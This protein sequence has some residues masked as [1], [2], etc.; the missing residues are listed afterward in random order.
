MGK[1]KGTVMDANGA[2]VVTPRPSIIFKGKNGVR[3]VVATDSGDYEIALPAGVYEVTTETPGF[4]PFRRAKFH[5]LPDSSVV[6]N[7]VLTPRYIIRGTTVS[8]TESTDTLAPSPQYNQ[9]VVPGRQIRL[10]IQFQTKRRPNG[11]I[12]YSGAILTYDALTIYTDKLSLNKIQLRLK[13]SGKQ[14]VVEDGKQ[15][16]QVKQAAVTFK[17]GE[18]ILDL[19][20]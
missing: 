11:N 16:I 13:A 15:R 9:F 2:V 19:T 12:E 6:I 8:T 20:R 18:P 14:V 7:V 1:V 10:L 3:T 5:V 17:R 4:Y